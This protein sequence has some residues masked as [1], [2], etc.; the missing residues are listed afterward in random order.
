MFYPFQ[1][2]HR[3][4]TPLTHFHLPR[5][6]VAIV[7]KFE[8]N[9]FFIFDFF[10]REYKKSQS[11]QPGHYPYILGG[12]NPFRALWQRTIDSFQT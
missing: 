8:C 12:C 4:T 9:Q 6:Q 2:D 5:P 10:L 11:C 1:K 7:E 3:H